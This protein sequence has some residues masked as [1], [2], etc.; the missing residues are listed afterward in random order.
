MVRMETRG[1]EQDLATRLRCLLLAC[2]RLACAEIQ[3]WAVE[4]HARTLLQLPKFELLTFAPT[5][6]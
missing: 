1:C 6:A 5:G 3:S 4:W 2:L